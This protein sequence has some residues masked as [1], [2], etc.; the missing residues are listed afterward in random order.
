MCSFSQDH[1]GQCLNKGLK[2]VQKRNTCQIGPAKELADTAR[3]PLQVLAHHLR[4][5]ASLAA[6]FLVSFKPLIRTVASKDQ[7]LGQHVDEGCIWNPPV[8]KSPMKLNVLYEQGP[9][10]RDGDGGWDSI[11]RR[12]LHHRLQFPTIP[13]CEDRDACGGI[14]TACR[15]VPPTMV[16]TLGDECAVCL[17]LHAVQVARKAGIVSHSIRV[18]HDRLAAQGQF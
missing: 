13:S 4:H 7:L 10:C 1:I 3:F 6:R 18:A 17:A 12:P 9:S 14:G 8:V 16:G 11:C 2:R 5:V 15:G